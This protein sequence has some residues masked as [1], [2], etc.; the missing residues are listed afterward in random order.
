LGFDKAE[1]VNRF[2]TKVP[3]GR[4][5]AEVTG[6]ATICGVLIEVGG[7]GLAT[8]IQPI[9]MGGALESVG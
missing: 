6:E 4:F 5:E 7:N 9:R 3:S 1:P 2:L 8:A